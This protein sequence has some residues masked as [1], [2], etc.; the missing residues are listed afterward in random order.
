MNFPQSAVS[1]NEYR[2]LK[3]VPLFLCIFVYVY[4]F[5]SQNYMYRMT[6]LFACAA[7]FFDEL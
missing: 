6:G 7:L 4:D 3:V 1:A 5:N 2:I